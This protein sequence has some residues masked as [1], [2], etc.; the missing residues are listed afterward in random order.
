M[1]DPRVSGLL[2]RVLRLSAHVDR[3]R[4]GKLAKTCGFTIYSISTNF[5][6][7]EELGKSHCLSVCPKGH[8]E[9]IGG[10]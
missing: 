2:G 3:R 1:R 10:G 9:A 8:V 6:L 5:G 7:P 4:V